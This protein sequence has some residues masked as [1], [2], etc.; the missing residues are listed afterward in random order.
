MAIAEDIIRY[1]PVKRTGSEQDSLPGRYSR[2]FQ[3][4]SMA[5][6]TLA[7]MGWHRLKKK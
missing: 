1:Q 5:A 6:F 7:L 2:V 4:L 3:W